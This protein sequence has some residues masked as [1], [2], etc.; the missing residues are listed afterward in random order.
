MVSSTTPRFDA[1]CPPLRLTVVTISSLISPARRFKSAKLKVLISLSRTGKICL[2]ERG[3]CF[4]IVYFL[5]KTEPGIPALFVLVSILSELFLAF[6]SGN[7]PKFAF[8]SAGHS[9]LLGLPAKNWILLQAQVRFDNTK[10]ER[11]KRQAHNRKTIT[12]RRQDRQGRRGWR[13]A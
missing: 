6:M 10:R 7:L 13:V 1:K 4:C 2:G 8:S 5:T 3:S 9:R 12:Q 11:I